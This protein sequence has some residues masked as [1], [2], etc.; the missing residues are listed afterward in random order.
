MRAACESGWDF[1][2]RWL[3]EPDSLSSTTN[4]RYNTHVILIVCFITQ[5][6]SL[7][8]LISLLGN[9][10]QADLFSD[11]AAARRTLINKY[12]WSEQQHFLLIIIITK[13]VNL[14]C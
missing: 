10:Q 7:V 13:R 12:M 5:K 11:Y 6:N 2:S 3:A 4:D 14:R 8:S 1:S 9:S